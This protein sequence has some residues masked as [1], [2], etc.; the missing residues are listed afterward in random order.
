MTTQ[1]LINNA[2][3][4][5]PMRAGDDLKC[6]WLFFSDVVNGIEVEVLGTGNKFSPDMKIRAIFFDG[7]ER[8]SRKVAEERLQ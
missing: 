6:D 8:I 1:D 7:S 2:L 3:K 5:E 4:Q